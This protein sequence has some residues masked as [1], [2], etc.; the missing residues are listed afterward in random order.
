MRQSKGASSKITANDKT[1]TI[2]ANEESGPNMSV[3]YFPGGDAML[4]VLTRLQ[5]LQESLQVQLQ[6]IHIETCRIFATADSMSI[7]A[8]ARH[9]ANGCCALF[10]IVSV[11]IVYLMCCTV[12]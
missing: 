4:E 5:T 8:I 11:L 1:S 3:D 9:I 10:Y 6:V 12:A 7:L 2:V